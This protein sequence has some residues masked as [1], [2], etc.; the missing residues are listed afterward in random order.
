M[1]HSMQPLV[2]RLAGPA[3]TD[4]VA[5]LAALDSSPPPEGSVLLAHRGAEAVAA[6]GIE[7]GRAVADP[8]RR[9]ADVVALLRER[10]NQLTG[11]RR[12]RYAAA[13]P[14]LALA[15]LRARRSATT[16]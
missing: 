16:R 4:V 1:A 9:T 2:I 13:A 12:P 11:E 15:P 10:A 8:F 5:R 14:L 7:S 3:D 6:L